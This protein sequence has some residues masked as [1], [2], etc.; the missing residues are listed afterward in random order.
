[1][2][3]FYFRENPRTGRDN[4]VIEDAHLIWKNFSGEETQF[5]RAGNRNFN[6]IIDDIDFA[7]ELLHKGWNVKEKEARDEGD[8]PYFT[9]A[10]AVSYK[11]RPPKIMTYTGHSKAELNEDTV[12]MLDYADIINVDLE[13]NG[14]HWEVNGKTGIKAYVNG[15]HVTIDDGAFG[16]KYCDYE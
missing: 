11:I 8:D 13:L 14:S 3:K 1:M 12:G 6:V 15:L 5:N 7:E 10:C 2:S 9:L 16:D 4:V